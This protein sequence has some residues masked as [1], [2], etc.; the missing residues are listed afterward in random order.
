MGTAGG[1]PQHERNPWAGPTQQG[2]GE[3]Q[4]ERQRPDSSLWHGRD[5]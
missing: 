3:T 4:G 2:K 1:I 5:R